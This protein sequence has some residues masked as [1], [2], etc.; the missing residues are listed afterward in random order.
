MGY[1]Y[2]LYREMFQL[3][4]PDHWFDIVLLSPQLFSICKAIQGNEIIS[5]ILKSTE[6]VITEVNG[7]NYIDMEKLQ[8][9]WSRKYW[10]IIVTNPKSTVEIWGRLIGPDH[11]VSSLKFTLNTFKHC[12][13]NFYFYFRINS[14]P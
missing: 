10:D 9:P 3:R 6:T 4:L 11:S 13:N 5:A 14:T 7:P 8:L 12:K 2:I 1:C